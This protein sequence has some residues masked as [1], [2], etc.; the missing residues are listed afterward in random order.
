MDGKTVKCVA[1]VGLSNYM[2]DDYGERAG[3]GSGNMPDGLNF[4]KPW[5]FQSRGELNT[6]FYAE[7]GAYGTY[8]QDG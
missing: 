8:P 5:S 2:V 1:G 4:S 7:L 3:D 6:T